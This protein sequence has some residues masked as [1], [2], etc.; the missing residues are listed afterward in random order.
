MYPYRTRFF[1]SAAV[2]PAIALVGDAPI[3]SEASLEWGGYLLPTLL[4]LA[5]FVVIREW[6][7]RMAKTRLDQKLQASEARFRQVVESNMIGILFWDVNGRIFDANEALLTMIGFTQSDLEEERINWR[8]MTPPEYAAL[9]ERAIDEIRARGACTPFEKEYI[10]KDGTRIPVIVGGALLRGEDHRG[11]C[12]V[13]NI[14][15]REATRRALNE[16]QA[17]LQLF[18]EHSPALIFIKDL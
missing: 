11:V 7:T 2:M 9:D 15:E 16:A 3:D 5:A 1:A 18:L 10:R 4:I 17:H 13:V 12:F 8:E 6:W 14:S